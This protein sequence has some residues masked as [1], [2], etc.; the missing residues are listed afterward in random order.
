M[1]PLRTRLICLLALGLA[2]CATPQAPVAPAARN[3]E[4]P[5]TVPGASPEL[6]RPTKP[7]PIRTFSVRTECSFRDETGNFGDAQVDVDESRVKALKVNLTLPRRGQCHF[8]LAQ[9]RQTRFLPSVELAGPGKCRI[10]MWEQQS[11]ISVAFDG[12]HSM[13]SPASAHDYVWP[14]LIDQATGQCD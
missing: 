1:L 10:H 7:M 13:C 14:L 4:A 5:A 12:C 3:P 8:D 2:A 6:G 11:Q 9:F